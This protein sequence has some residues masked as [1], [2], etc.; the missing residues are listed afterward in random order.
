M[1]EGHWG[2]SRE[3]WEKFSCFYEGYTRRDH[4]FSTL[5][6]ILFVYF[7]WSYLL[8]YHQSKDKLMQRREEA[9]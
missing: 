8:F 9:R 5:H 4:S 1:R 7:V 3:F 2:G 6:I